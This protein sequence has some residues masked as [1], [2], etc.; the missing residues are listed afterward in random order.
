MKRRIRGFTLI[1]LLVVIA[2]I[3]IL[4]AILL[5][6]LAR[7]RESARRASCQNNLKQLGLT[8]KMYAGE[9]QGAFPP[10]KSTNCDGT[11]TE[12]MAAIPDM[13]AVYPEYLSDFNVLV[14]P[15]SPFAG[16]PEDL[17]DEGDNPS[18]A[19]EHAHEEGHL[20][21]A[22]NGRVE[23][24]EVY[25]HPY[26]YFGWALDAGLLSRAEAIEAF[27]LALLEEPD[28]LIHRLEANPAAAHEDWQLPAPLLPGTPDTVY[29]LREGIERFLITDINNPG[30]ASQAQSTL[31]VMWDCLG[32]EAS[33]FN[34][35]P[36]GCNVLY[37]DGH[38]EFLRYNP[39]QTEPNTGNAFPV[40]GAGLVIHEA[41]HGGHDEHEH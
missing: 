18:T 2:I 11:P 22:G 15:S 33:H 24:C 31:A 13:T 4:A 16:A 5:P 20:P 25:D 32:H 34:H 26:I 29:R 10:L 19:W 28:G 23:P 14:C 6:A 7:A 9:A 21:L 36:G 12:G 37:M 30:G 17:W 38:V 1:E 41:T 8:F 27:E 3:G 39:M 40:N 35:V